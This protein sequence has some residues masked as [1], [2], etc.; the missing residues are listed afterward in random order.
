MIPLIACF[1]AGPDL[2]LSDLDRL[3]DRVAS[4]WVSFENRTGA[5]GNGGKEN[6][7]GKGRPFDYLRPGK[8]FVVADID[9]PGTIRRMWFTMNDRSPV[10]MRSIRIDIYW[11]R[12]KKPAVSAPFADFFGTGLANSSED[13]RIGLIVVG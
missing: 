8:S 12:E 1:A 3:P 11:D 10:A 2:G 5:K 13:A 7:G 4:R 6:K 9:G